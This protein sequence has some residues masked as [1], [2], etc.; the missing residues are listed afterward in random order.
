METLTEKYKPYPAYKPSGVAWLGEV[1]AHWEVQRLKYLATVNDE[2]LPETTAPDLEMTYVDIGNVDSIAGITG[3]EDLLFEDA[4]S[5]ARRIVRQ[6]DVIISTVRTYLK[7]IARIEPTDTNLIVSTG[8]AVIRPQELDGGFAAYALSS[9][10]FVDRVVA[11]SVGVSYPAINASELACLDIAFPPLPE[12]QA[13]AAFL[14][15]ET[16]RIDALVAKK[17][18]LIELL[19]EKRTALI[20]RAV[21]RGLDPEAP[22]QDSGVEWFREI[23]AHWEVKPLKYL[24]R[25]ALQYGANEPSS[26]IDPDSPRY[27]RITDIDEDGMLRD[28]TFRSLPS[29]IAEPYLLSEGDLLFAR[30]GAT[31]GKTFRYRPSWGIAAYAGYLIRARFDDLVVN[32]AFID[33]FTRSQSYADWLLSNFIQSTIQNV[34]AERYANLA[35]P[36]PPLPEQNAITAFLDGETAKLDS[37][38]AKIR[39]AIEHLRELRSALISA[40]VTGQIDVREEAGCK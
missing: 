1:P 22:M 18:R 25:E 7:A 13:I 6:G 14:D 33:Y 38:I 30:S 27:I 36:K 11:H 2:A 34:S 10:Y 40:A 5:R 26:H 37:L 21:T 29:E 17:E 39:E 8:F 19:Q 3:T 9:P 28:D 35:V 23:T 15:G 32:P 4:P 24:L 31:V 12:Q 16:A 20:T